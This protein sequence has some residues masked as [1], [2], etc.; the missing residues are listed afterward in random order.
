MGLIGQI[1]LRPLPSRIKG[2]DA[3]NVVGFSYDWTVDPVALQNLGGYSF[4]GSVFEID[5]SSIKSPA[6]SNLKAFKSLQ[7]TQSFLNAPDTGPND[8]PL[9]IYVENTGQ[10]IILGEQFEADGIVADY[11]ILSAVIPIVSTAPTKIQF[12]KA[13]NGTAVFGKLRASLFDFDIP[14]YTYY[15]LSADQ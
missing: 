8:G 10:L 6:T 5:V 2:G 4:F 14:P 9:I 3:R 13:Y 11:S 15:G 7:L 1:S 12:G